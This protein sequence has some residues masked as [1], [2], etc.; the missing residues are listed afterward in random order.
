M[1]FRS[2]LW[3]VKTSSRNP[4]FPHHLLLLLPG[5]YFPP[6]PHHT[7]HSQTPSIHHH[8]PRTRSEKENPSWE[9]VKFQPPESGVLTSSNDKVC[10]HL[11]YF[12]PWWFGSSQI[13]LVLVVSQCCQE[14]AYQQGVDFLSGFDR[15]GNSTYKTDDS[16]I[17]HFKQ[18]DSEMKECS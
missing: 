4:W 8:H 9:S 17:W 10:F 18:T 13:L 14:I 2:K 6:P 11:V 15:F 12:F 16:I 1:I 5:S 3:R 7:W